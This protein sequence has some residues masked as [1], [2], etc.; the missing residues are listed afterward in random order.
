MG[1]REIFDA[2][3]QSQALVTAERGG[4]PRPTPLNSPG[5]NQPSRPW[6]TLVSFLRSVGSVALQ[7]HLLQGAFHAPQRETSKTETVTGPHK[8][9][10]V[11]GFSKRLGN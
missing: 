9:V 5:K 3:Q 6:S 1:T 2:S 4:S 11:L 8:Q 7:Q 10:A